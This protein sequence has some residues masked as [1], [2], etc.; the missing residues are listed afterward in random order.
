[1]ISIHATD[2]KGRSHQL[3]VPCGS[4]LMESLRDSDLGVEA[5]CGGQ[6]ACGTC[7]CLIHPAW[8]EIVGAPGEDE[9]ELLACL[10]AFDH[11]RSRLTC[12]IEV[13]DALEG[14]SLTVAPEE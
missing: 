14:L 7:H 8:L 1:M 2:R 3:Q 9:R 12:Q 6:C 4:V 5:I 11:R 13:S 10:D